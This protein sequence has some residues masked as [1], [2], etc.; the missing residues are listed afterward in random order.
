[1]KTT[2]LNEH[3]LWKGK[4]QQANYPT[5]KLK[6]D[7]V[8]LIKINSLTGTIVHGQPS[9]EDELYQKTLNESK[10]YWK[11]VELRKKLYRESRLL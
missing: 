9:I 4:I 5:P 1:M 11:G 7:M 10:E 6:K 3:L 8:G 2:P